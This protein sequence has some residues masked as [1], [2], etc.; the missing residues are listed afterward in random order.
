MDV[1]VALTTASPETIVAV[2]GAGSVVAVVVA[3]EGSV[4][5]VATEVDAVAGVAV[6]EAHVEDAVVARTVEV[7]GIMQD[8]RLPFD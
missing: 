3:V 6:E 1:L 7:S 4:A 8:E 5:V 2:I